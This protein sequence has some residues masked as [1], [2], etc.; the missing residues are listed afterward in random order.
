[1]VPTKTGQNQPVGIVNNLNIA[2]K[3]C[4]VVAALKT[5]FVEYLEKAQTATKVIGTLQQEK[6]IA[7]M[8]TGIAELSSYAS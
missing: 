5:K 6:E 2:P 4:S 1:M 7:H 3:N 8:L